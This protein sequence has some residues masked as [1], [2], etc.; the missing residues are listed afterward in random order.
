MSRFLESVLAPSRRDHAHIQRVNAL[1]AEFSRLT[2]AE[3]RA[4]AHD[5]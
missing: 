4:A 1:R 5:Q 2:D 3:L